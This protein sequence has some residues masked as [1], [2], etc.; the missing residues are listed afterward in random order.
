MV[1]IQKDYRYQDMSGLEGMKGVLAY[2]YRAF[3]VSWH[4][5]YRFCSFT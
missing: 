1:Y 4:D 5:D 3:S 2:D